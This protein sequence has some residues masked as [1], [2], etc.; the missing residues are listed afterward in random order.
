MKDGK[1]NTARRLFADTMNEIKSAGHM[2]PKGVV[3]TAIDNASPSIMIK[4]K[5]VGGSVYQVPVE[6]HQKRRMY[7]ACTWLIDAA[8]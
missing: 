1:K 5:R 6:V 2:N 7:F 8:A 4:S 3:F